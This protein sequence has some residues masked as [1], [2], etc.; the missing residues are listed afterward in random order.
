M[1][2]NVIVSRAKYD[3]IPEN[4]DIHKGK[5]VMCITTGEVFKSARDAANY[6]GISYESLLQQI[7]GKQK[8]CGGTPHNHTGKGKQFCYISEMGYNAD[9]ISASII[10]MSTDIIEMKVHSVAKEDYAAAMQRNDELKK[11][12]DELETENAE[13]KFK[14]NEKDLKINELQKENKINNNKGKL[15]R[16]F[17][18]LVG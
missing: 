14:L 16:I 17:S 9:A 13:L 11:R 3:I 7:A 5:A 6:Y 1:E 18:A 12:N 10:K 8:T 15:S 4:K 2:R